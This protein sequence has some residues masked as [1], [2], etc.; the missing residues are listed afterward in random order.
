V[1]VIVA[2]PTATAVTTPEFALTEA[3]PVAELD[4]VTTRPVRTLLLASR[5]VAEREVVP[6]TNRL[7]DDGETDT[8]ATGTG[9]GA[10]TVIAAEAVLPSL[11]AVMVAVPAATAVT[12]PEFE[13][14]EA[15]P[16]AELDHVT[17]RPVSTL[18]PAS[19]VVAES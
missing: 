17:T 8:L 1:A 13:L 19:R 5:V 12:R 11:V 4:H 14:T 16:E 9:A 15:I 10:V 2:L 7:D 3:I 18:L 6:P